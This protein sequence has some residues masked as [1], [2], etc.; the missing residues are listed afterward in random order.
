[1][2]IRTKKRTI[3]ISLISIFVAIL[4]LVSFFM[5]KPYIFRSSLS[6]LLPDEKIV[7]VVKVRVTHNG[8]REEIKTELSE[9]KI[10]LFCDS[11]GTLKYKE[12]LNIVKVRT[13]IDESVYYIIN[14]ENYTVHLGKVYFWVDDHNGVSKKWIR[15]S[16][17]Y[18]DKTYDE[19]ENLFE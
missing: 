8:N 3:L 10:D 18:P 16:D 4:V 6:K 19:L 15:F 1:M 5:V 9:E 17:I 12:Y 14:Y 7:S 11:L 2:Q 13:W